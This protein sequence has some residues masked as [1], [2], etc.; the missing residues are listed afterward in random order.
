MTYCLPPIRSCWECYIFKHFRMIKCILKRFGLMQKH[1]E[2][3][4]VYCL[5]NIA[6]SNISY[7]TINRF[8]FPLF[9]NE[10]LRQIHCSFINFI[11]TL[12]ILYCSFPHPANA[13]NGTQR[14]ILY[15]L[16]YES[17][18]IYMYN[19]VLVL[20]MITT[21]FIVQFVTITTKRVSLVCRH[22]SDTF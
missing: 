15:L 1:R 6:I 17:F 13:Q 21:W 11:V 7:R 9:Y 5:R 20:Y 4:S 14:E 2:M 18:F 3:N 16:L 12:S 8:C 22:H 19:M 10:N